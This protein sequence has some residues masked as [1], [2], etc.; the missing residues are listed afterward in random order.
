MAILSSVKTAH[1]SFLDNDCHNINSMKCMLSELV[2]KIVMK[3]VVQR[4]KVNE[5]TMLFPEHFTL[6]L[7]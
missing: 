7:N 3:L 6:Y 5:F 2:H 4:Y 1:N